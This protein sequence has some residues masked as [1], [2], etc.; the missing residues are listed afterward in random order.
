MLPM[1][2]RRLLA[3]GFFSFLTGFLSGARAEQKRFSDIGELRKAVIEAMRRE[4]GVA[5]VSPDPNDPAKIFVRIGDHNS[6]SDITNL[7][8]RLR[9]YPD[10]DAGDLIAQ[11]ARGVTDIPDRSVS[12]DNLVA[13]LRTEAYVAELGKMQG[14]LMA[15]PFAGELNIVYMADM[16]DSMSAI[17]AEEAHGKSLAQV[18]EIAFAN[19]R[20][21]LDK[22]VSDDQLGAATLYYVDVNTMLSPSLVLFDEFW[23]SIRHRYPGDVLIA[24]PRRDQL[25]IID[26]NADG[27][28][29]AQAVIKA[30]L[31]DD[32][33]ILSATLFARRNGK[34]VVVEE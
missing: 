25:F 13:V 5:S 8:N 29:L 6:T 33:A 24:V 31:A 2:R 9:A 14:T 30:T 10:E 7:F 12:D 3:M 21:W 26:D 16:P 11:F 19:V 20:K 15:E 17:S 27:K 28:A 22:V 23:N 32:F 1:A 4:P 34:I 18:R